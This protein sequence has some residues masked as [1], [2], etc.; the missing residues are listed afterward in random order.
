[1]YETE[2]VQEYN[3]WLEDYNSQTNNE[4]EAQPNNWGTSSL[5]PPQNGEDTKRNGDE[6]EIEEDGNDTEHARAENEQ[7]RPS[8]TQSKSQDIQMENPKIGSDIIDNSELSAFQSLR[9]N[10]NRKQP[11]NSNK[12]VNNE[13]RTENYITK[14]TTDSRKNEVLK[15]DDEKLKKLYKSPFGKYLVLTLSCFINN[16]IACINYYAKSTCKMKKEYIRIKKYT[17]TQDNYIK[18]LDG[19]I[20]DIILEKHW[21]GKKDF[22][23]IQKS[24]NYLLEK[25]MENKKEKV[26]LLK[27]IVNSKVKDMFINY[28]KNRRF[29]SYDNCNFFLRGYKTLRDDLNIYDEEVNERLIKYISSSPIESNIELIDEI[30]KE[31]ELYSNHQTPDYQRREILTKC[32]DSTTNVITKNSKKYEEVS[33]HGVTIK[34]QIKNGFDDYRNFSEKTLKEIYCNS[35]PRHFNK[36]S[37]YKH[38]QEEIEKVLGKEKEDGTLHKLFGFIKFIDVLKA[39]LFDQT[40]IRIK[41]KSGITHKIKLDGFVTYKDYFSKYS[42]EDRKFIKRDFIEMM[43]GIKQGRKRSGSRAQTWASKRLGL[44]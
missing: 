31:E 34:K 41:D 18:I 42:E 9:N 32:K 38:Q 43:N 33:F 6:M 4:N 1:M 24:L 40:T 20:I 2:N 10:K 14:C 5:N 23:E 11:Q 37:E 29:A 16:I 15:S 36:D 22:L 13:E 19:L 7:R 17:I 44:K 30:N 27:I 35:L 12:L 21:K 3:S 26:K 39:F 25:E 8:K 28:L